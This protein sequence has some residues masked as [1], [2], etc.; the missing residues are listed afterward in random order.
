MSKGRQHLFVGAIDNEK[1]TKEKLCA[2][3]IKHASTN[4]D[5]YIT[6]CQMMSYNEAI[7]QGKSSSFLAEDFLLNE[8]RK[9]ICIHPIY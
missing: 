1:W 8:I 4:D 3:L 9:I 7:F 2:Y 5:Q 6:D